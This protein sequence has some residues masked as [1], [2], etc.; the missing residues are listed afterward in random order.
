MADGDQGFVGPLVEP[1]DA[2]AVHYGRELAGT[3]SQ[4]G[5]NRRE[6]EDNLK[7]G[8]VDHS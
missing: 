1:V 6:T 8:R 4:S 5:A 3:H 2:G 7:V